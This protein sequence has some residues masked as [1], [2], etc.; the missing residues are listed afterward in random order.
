MLYVCEV[1]EP[2]SRQLLLCATV[3]VCALTL[4]LG[5]GVA[6]V[7]VLVTLAFVGFAVLW[8]RYPHVL[9]RHSTP[10]TST[11]RK[12]AP[13]PSGPAYTF[14][15][16]TAVPTSPSATV[17]AAPTA[18]PA[19]PP[20][21]AADLAE[22]C[23]AYRTS[24]P[25]S[26]TEAAVLATPV[27]SPALAPHQELA[28]ATLGLRAR[29]HANKSSSSASFI[30]SSDDVPQ[31]DA[32]SGDGF[33]DF[34]G[35]GDVYGGGGGFNSKD[36]YKDEE[37]QKEGEQEQETESLFSDNGVPDVYGTGPLLCAY[38]TSM[39]EAR[40]RY[41][42]VAAESVAPGTFE[43]KEAAAQTLAALGVSSALLPT[44]RARCAA[45]LHTAVVAPLG[46]ALASAQ[47]ARPDAPLT[48]LRA[49]DA[50]L[51]AAAAAL[52]PDV[53][54]AALAARISALAAQHRLD[55]CDWRGART[56][57]PDARGLA[58]LF[59][60]LCDRSIPASD[61]AAGAAASGAGA[62]N[63]AFGASAFT[64]PFGAFAPP[65]AHT[66]AF[67]SAHFAAG[68]GMP[69]A[70][71]ARERRAVL[72]YERTRAPPHYEVWFDGR[73]WAVEPGLHNFFSALVLFA[74]A[75]DLRLD[76]HLGPLSLRSPSFNLLT[77]I[78][79]P[80]PLSPNRFF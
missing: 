32:P 2:F 71:R 60:A 24:G 68:P 56:G 45:W 75:V 35:D 13:S 77:S 17:L 28:R 27:A 44:L 39:P 30:A 25:I 42:A 22:L 43:Y 67:T 19:T 73:C 16:P 69:A 29:A 10:A 78:N 66:G 12:S 47:R 37:D 21:S 3:L 49:R 79:F 62:T 26:A 20:A 52:V 38:Q 74:R 51:L 8:H 53:A 50:Q 23:R 36:D 6:L 11:P 9:S 59:C 31:K 70:A 40:A 7:P 34:Y 54:P 64:S 55:D 14:S 80:K 15:F 1:V 4:S 65:Y 5:L 48:A 33:N 72:L 41:S 76:G 61:P 58:A 46:A 57:V 63:S 18:P